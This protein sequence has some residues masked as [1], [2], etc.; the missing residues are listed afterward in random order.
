ML[1]GAYDAFINSGNSELIRNEPLTKLLAEYFSIVKSGFEDQENSMNLL[2][3][4]QN[5]LAPVFVNI[6]G[7]RIGF[8][9]LRSP[10]EDSAIDFLFKQDAFFGNL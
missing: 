3:N 2:N 5:I 10:K 4:M 6:R 1:T 9:T 8:D 7:S